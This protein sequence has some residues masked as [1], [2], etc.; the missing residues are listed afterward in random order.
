MTDLLLIESNPQLRD[1]LAQELR[2]T[3]LAVTAEATPTHSF[4]DFDIAVADAELMFDDAFGDVLRSTPVVLTAEP[5]TVRDAVTAIKSGAADYLC[6]PFEPAELVASVERALLEQGPSAHIA[7]GVDELVGRSA[8]ISNLRAQIDRAAQTD[9]T[10]LICGASGTGKELV[11]RAL[12]ANSHRNHA[13]L[14]SINCAAVPE[15]LIEVEL[16]GQEGL[17]HGSEH[18]GLLHAA[19]GGTLLLDEV[20]EL[21]RETQ[22]RLLRVLA[23]GEMRAVGATTPT[24]IDVRIIATTHHDLPQLVASGRF[25]EDLYYRLNVVTLHPPPLAER[26]EDVPLLAERFLQRTARRL[27]RQELTLTSDA[28]TRM[29]SYHWPGNVREL[30]NAIERAVI[31]AEGDEIAAHLLAIDVPKPATPSPALASEADQTSLEDYFVNFV[32]EHQ[33]QLTETELA[34]KL[35]ISRKSLWERR[36]RLNIPRRKTR[37]RGP[38]T[39]TS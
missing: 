17:K 32:L 20:G 6:K 24:S 4:S 5:G 21:P 36:Q 38:R 9:T 16:F 39:N 28:L 1:R 12:H 31:L 30:E 8:A 19:S 15:G 26:L 18:H 25:R 35:G 33:D 22:A 27:N 3:G 2:R 34:Q 7:S 13:P 11:A 29:M 10:V 37:K 14:I 23:D